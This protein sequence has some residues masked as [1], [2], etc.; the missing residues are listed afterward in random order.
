MAAQQQ[1]AAAAAAQQ[2]NGYGAPAPPRAAGAGYPAPLQQVTPWQGPALAY[3]PVD[4]P[5]PADA[6]AINLGD[7]DA[8]WRPVRRKAVLIGARRNV[9]KPLATAGGPA[10]GQA[11]LQLQLA[12]S[13]GCWGRRPDPSRSPRLHC[14]GINYLRTPRLALRGCINDAHCMR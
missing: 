6:P 10:G 5:A 3:G 8:A 12:M 14:P 7:P 1:A 2:G 9:I 13:G 4:I 11:E